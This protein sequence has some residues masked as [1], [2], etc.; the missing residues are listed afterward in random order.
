MKPSQVLTAVLALWAKGLWTQGE[1]HEYRRPMKTPGRN[2]DKN[3]EGPRAKKV[4]CFCLDGALRKVTLNK[5]G[6][7]IVLQRS[8]NF[9]KKAL[10]V[11]F[12]DDIWEWNDDRKRTLAQIISV[13]KKARA[14]AL[15]AGA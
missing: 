12:D 15:K 6:G 1:F 3:R 14:L 10:G 8:H 4:Q 11:P 7:E 2:N 5:K 9:I 13:T